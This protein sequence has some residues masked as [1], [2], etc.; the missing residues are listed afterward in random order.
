MDKKELGKRIRI[1]RLERGLEQER[2]EEILD[3]PQQAMHLIESG[4]YP[5]STLILASLAELFHTHVGEF[6]GETVK[7][8]WFG[9]LH[10]IAPT[11]EG[12]SADLKII[13][14]IVEAYRQEE[15]SQGRVRELCKLLNVPIEQ[16]FDLADQDN[17]ISLAIENSQGT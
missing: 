7:D 10:R 9:E 12:V 17:E 11:R 3:L 1:A 15:I 6:F 16:I 8:D 2:I 4:E 5:I 13:N 14:K